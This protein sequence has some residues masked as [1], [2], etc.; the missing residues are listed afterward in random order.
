MEKKTFLCCLK[1]KNIKL[2][3]TPSRTYFSWGEVVGVGGADP[4]LDQASGPT[5]QFKENIGH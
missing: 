1:I 2:Y 5:Y 4:E 3:R